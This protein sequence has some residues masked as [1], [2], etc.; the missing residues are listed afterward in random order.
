MKKILVPFSVLAGAARAF[1]DDDCPNLAAAVAFYCIISVIP[2]LFL[3]FFASGMVLGSSERAYVAVAEFIRE[4][5]PYV[6]EKLLFEIKRLSDTT[7]FMG[8]IG[9]AVLLWISTMVV[10][11]LETAFTIIFRVERRRNPFVS[12][13]MAVAVIPVGVT[14]IL[15]LVGIGTVK[16][17]LE[18]YGIERLTAYNALIGYVIPLLVIIVFFTLLFKVIPHVKVSFSHALIGGVTCTLFLELAKYLFTMYLSL[19]GNPVGFVYGSLKAL[20]YVVIWVFYLAYMT[21]FTGEI[22][23]ILEKR[24]GDV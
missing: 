4:L 6:E 1:F 16:G 19:G 14:A 3:I 10:T 20:I 17:F 23:S 2:I 9:L 13:F 12:L 11:S 5:H 8:W 22:V 15:F 24:K 18:G 7:G 21:L